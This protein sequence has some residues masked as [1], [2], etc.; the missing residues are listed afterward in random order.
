MANQL[1]MADVEAIVALGRHGWSARRIAL[2]LGIHRETVG[3]YLQQAAAGS[4]PASAP[5]GSGGGIE[6]AAEA[7]PASAPLGSEGS[8]PEVS[9]G[10]DAPSG[11]EGAPAGPD[12]LIGSN[13]SAAWPWRQVIAQKLKEGLDAQ[14]IYQDLGDPQQGHGYSGSYYSVRRL[15]KKLTGGHEW[16]VRRMECAA[17]AEAQV[18][19]GKGAA[20]VGA[21]GARKGSWVFRIILSHSRRGYS[22]AVLRQGTDEFLRCLENAFAHFGGLARTLVI[23]NLRAAVTRADWYDPEL[24]PKVRSFAEHYGIAILPTKPYTPRHKGKIENGVKYVK[25]NCL[26]GRSF[27]SL[28]EE[29]QHLLA[30]ESSVADKRIHGTTR[31]QVIKLFA[32]AEKPALLPLPAG[33]FELFSEALRSVHRD[34]HVQIKGAYYSLPPEYLGQEVWARW[35]GR[36]V[37]LFDQKMR[38]IAV[39]AQQAPGRFSTHR[40][41]IVPEKISG[42]ERGTSWLLGQVDRIGPM[43]KAWAEAMLASR[44]IEGVRVLMGLLNLN[45]QHGRAQIERACEVARGHGAYHLR[46]LR[47]LIQQGP[48]AP[49][50]QN[51]EFADQHPIIRPVADY[52]QFVRESLA[53]SFTQERA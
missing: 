44:G 14:R 16:P 45:N 42:I 15:V 40:A 39:H 51:F 50:Q 3:H 20:I 53:G 37:R 23:D 2:E 48:K 41:H 52:G 29:N 7:K 21:D 4:K 47:Q 25:N 19:F 34:G 8:M 1:K 46:S 13:S 27:S 11:P 31:Q 30:W 49:V 24:C 33:R 38:P 43:A 22:E 26:K 10:A 5:A 6:S 9:G 35:D 17:G 28:A 32:E 12:E 18:D 36:L